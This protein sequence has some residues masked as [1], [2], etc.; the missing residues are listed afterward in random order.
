[1]KENHCFVLTIVIRALDCA[2]RLDRQGSIAGAHFWTSERVHGQLRQ[3]KG[4]A[5]KRLTGNYN[6]H[7]EP[8]TDL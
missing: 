4:G 7:F 6:S 5:E 8:Y 1:M 3:W 2:K